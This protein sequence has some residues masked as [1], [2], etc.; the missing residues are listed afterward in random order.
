M[1]YNI[2][3]CVL[4]LTCKHKCLGHTITSEQCKF[5]RSVRH[6]NTYLTQ[7]CT[8]RLIVLKYFCPEHF[9]TSCPFKRTCKTWTSASKY[10][11]PQH[12]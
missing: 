9:I 12:I 6:D 5:F 7:S 4:I 3:T 1:Y 10:E 8:L 11:L 2:K